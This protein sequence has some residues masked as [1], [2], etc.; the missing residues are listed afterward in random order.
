MN[1][2]RE[3]QNAI[4]KVYDTE[5]IEVLSGMDMEYK[6]PNGKQVLMWNSEVISGVYKYQRLKGIDLNPNNYKFQKNLNNLL[7]TSDEIAFFI[8]NAG[9]YMDNMSNP[10]DDAKTYYDDESKKWVTFYPNFPNLESKRYSMF[11]SV[12]Y[13]KIYNYWDRLGDLLWATYFQSDLKERNV[14][15]N[16][17][18]DVIKNKY[19]L[20]HHLISFQWLQNFKDNEYKALND[21]RKNI[22][23]YTSI[24]V[25]FKMAHLGQFQ[26]AEG[27][28]QN[29][30]S[31]KSQ[32]EKIMK[33]RKDY[34]DILKTHI[35]KSIEGFVQIHQLIEDITEIELAKI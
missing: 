6:L 28:S 1:I 7:F 32:V 24:D 10:I 33:E 29:V 9:I 4:R 26:N 17:I 15:F 12:A 13:E 14:D 30:F 3:I 16:K 25:E 22:V 27:R 21:V 35:S 8:A 31:D 19:P 18:I 34:F 5:K 2:V 20:Y 23:H 11:I